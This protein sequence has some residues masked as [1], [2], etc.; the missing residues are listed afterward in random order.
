MLII[1]PDSLPNLATNQ[2][3]PHCGNTA[4]TNAYKIGIPYAIKTL[5]TACP[6]CTLYVDAAHGKKKMKC[7]RFHD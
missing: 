6:S 5:A 7:K 1:E 3:D 2:G 4:T